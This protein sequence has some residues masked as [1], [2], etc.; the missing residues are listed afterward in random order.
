MTGKNINELALFLSVYL[1]YS[2]NASFHPKGKEDR[3]RERHIYLVYALSLLETWEAAASLHAISCINPVHW[4]VKFNPQRLWQN[5]EKQTSQT[6]CRA[7][8]LLCSVTFG[9]A[10][11]TFTRK[12]ACKNEEQTPISQHEL[13]LGVLLIQSMQLAASNDMQ[14][15]NEH[16]ITLGCQWINRKQLRVQYGKWQ[17]LVS[18]TK[19]QRENREISLSSTQFLRMYLGENKYCFAS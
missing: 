3:Y 7:I 12:T 17:P 11:I 18:K 15:C 5:Y 13:W 9:G 14:L 2:S 10:F 1:I 8:S 6:V 19:V 16:H 4:G